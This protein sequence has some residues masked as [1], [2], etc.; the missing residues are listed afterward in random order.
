MA[1][2]VPAQGV[3]C[4]DSVQNQRQK[5]ACVVQSE[6]TRGGNCF[7]QILMAPPVVFQTRKTAA[8]SVCCCLRARSPVLRSC[9]VLSDTRCA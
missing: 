8:L 1:H 9:M 6:L 4:V 3:D 5:P 7:D 2:S